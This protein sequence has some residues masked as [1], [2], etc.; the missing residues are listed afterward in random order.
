[1]SDPYR[2]PGKTE[3]VKF[4]IL[5]MGGKNFRIVQTD[6]DSFVLEKKVEKQNIDSLGWINK[7]VQWE[8]DYPM[9]PATFYGESLRGAEEKLFH[10]WKLLVETYGE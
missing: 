5:R 1:M 10:I 8:K 9:N 7:V 6:K 3:Q 2:T 4:P